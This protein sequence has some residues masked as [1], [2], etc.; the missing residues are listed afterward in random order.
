[1]FLDEQIFTI[2][3]KYHSVGTVPKIQSTN[4]RNRGKIDTLM[5]IHDRSRSWLGASNLVQYTLVYVK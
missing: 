2:K 1:M 4:L 3:G 5:Q